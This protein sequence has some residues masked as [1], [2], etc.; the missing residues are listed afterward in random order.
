MHLAFGRPPYFYFL[1]WS[2][3]M[4]H[5]ELLKKIIPMLKADNSITA[6]MLMGSVAAETENQY[7]DLNLFIL[8]GKNKLQSEI[9]DDIMV[10]YLYFT[11]EAAQSKL[12]K[13]GTEVY[14]YLGSKIIYDM[15]GRLIKLMRNAMNKYKKYKSADKEKLEL[16][17]WLYNA[18][19][20]IK[21]AAE[22]QDRLKVD[23]VTSATTDKII[24]SVFAINDVPLPPISRMFHELQNLKHIPE[25]DWF[26][27]LFNRNTSRRTEVSISAIEWA[28]DL[29]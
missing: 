5:Q 29:L 24:E 8:G 22:L 4:K 10:E 23:Y 25:P 14:R 27:N 26:E 17:I 1:Y 11:P 3:M 21:A 19:S 2:D 12:D 15:D 9:M 6:V 16:R 20:K 7:S 18:R 28:L 13:Y